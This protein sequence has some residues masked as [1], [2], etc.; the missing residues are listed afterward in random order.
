MSEDYTASLAPGGPGWPVAAFPMAATETDEKLRSALE[1]TQNELVACQRLALLG[2]LAGMAAHEFNNLMTPVVALVEAALTAADPALTHKALDRTLIQVQRAIGLSDHLLA[3]AHREYRP[4]ELCSVAA[5]VREALETAVR[6]FQ[7]DGIE[8]RVTVPEELRVCAQ[9]A[10]LCQVLLN[11]LLNARQ[12]MQGRRG[13]LTVTAT[14]DS[15]HVQ[16]DVRDSG[17][18]IPPDRLATVFNPFLAA[19]PRAR[20]QDWQTVGLGL[21]VCRL[22]AHHHGA[23]LRA[24]PNDGP[25]C[26]FRLRWPK[27]PPAS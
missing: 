22:I 1:S 8:L 17:K 3:L 26:T 11:L 23:T 9:E 18:G 19:D 6:P 27:H 7:K 5:A 4:A 13:V 2:S 21:S 15:D 20:P 14:A 12:A 16:I 24:L 25:G 10:L